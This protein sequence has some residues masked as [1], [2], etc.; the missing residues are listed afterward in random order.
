MPKFTSVK[1][2]SSMFVAAAIVVT[3]SQKSMGDSMPEKIQ[4]GNMKARALWSKANVK[5]GKKAPAL[6]L[7]P[8]SGPNGPEEMMPGKLTEDGKPH[9][10]FQQISE[11]F[12]KQNFNV[13]SLG[14]PG[15]EFFSR[16]DDQG[17]FDLQVLFYDQDLFKKLTWAGLIDNLAAGIDFLKHQP[18]VDT[19]K[20][21]ILG[22]SEG[23]QIASDYAKRDSSIA[24]YILLGY[25]GQNIKKIL[26][27]QMVQRPMEHFIKTDIDPKH[28]GFVTKADTANWPSPILLDD[29]E[30]VW[31]WKA[32]Q[33]MLTYAEIEMYLRK[34]T[35]IDT[36]LAKCKASP[37]YGAVCD[38]LDFYSETAKIKSPIY[39]F[40]GKLDLQTPPSEAVAL[41]DACDK[42]GKRDC[43]LH[44]IP[45]VGHGF[46]RPRGPRR[47]PLADLTVGPVNQNTINEL[48]DLASRLRK[49]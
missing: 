4:I 46:S 24:G 33:D 37:F 44:L 48:N 38:R 11:P 3:A 5:E 22:H 16:W 26:E 7:I 29:A 43:Y 13:I 12:V 31:P 30:F 17:W 2:L 20:I 27:W 40:T 9:S 10:L 42:I 18:T 14:K 19:K 47:H 41:K 8:G 28:R 49:K 1:N 21:Y 6:I 39:I 15:I 36:T 35:K 34:S 32:D 23:T 25:S 45:D